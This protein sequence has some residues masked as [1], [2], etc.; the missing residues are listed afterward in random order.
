MKDKTKKY[1]PKEILEAQWAERAS[2]TFHC[3]LR[4]LNTEPSIHVD[5]Y[6]QVLV[7]MAKQLQRRRY[8]RNRPIRNKNCMWCRC[9]LTDR[10]EMS[11][12]HRGHFIDAS[13]QVSVVAMFVNRSGRNEQFS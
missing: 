4:K 1:F 11:N 2:L 9:L 6:Y 13:Y 3:A 8:F 12:L 10:D 5:A 7:H